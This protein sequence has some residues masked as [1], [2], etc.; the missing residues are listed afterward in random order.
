MPRAGQR[1]S[2]ASQTSCL[3]STTA[4]SCATTSPAKVRC[5]L[6][7][8]CICIVLTCL[9]PLI[10]VLPSASQPSFPSSRTAALID[11]RTGYIPSNECAR[12]TERA[13]RHAGARHG[14]PAHKTVSVSHSCTGTHRGAGARV[15]TEMAGVVA[16]GCVKG[17][18][19]EQPGYMVAATPKQER[20][21]MCFTM[22]TDKAAFSC[23]SSNPNSQRLCACSSA[24][25]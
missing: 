25:S 2:P 3:P 15:L 7:S 6:T 11:T 18:G 13:P 20:P 24:A 14:T 1:A 10:W 16:A 22:E 17:G 9:H 23:S 4:T 19:N 12:V 8:T 21:T 5:S